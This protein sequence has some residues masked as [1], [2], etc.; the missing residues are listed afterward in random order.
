MPKPVY[1][2]LFSPIDIG[3]VR[4]KNRVVMTGFPLIVAEDTSR[5][6]VVHDKYID[7][8]EARAKGG[9]GLIVLPDTFPDR[10]LRIQSHPCIGGDEFN[11]GLGALTEAVHT[12]GAK[13]A[14][15]LMFPGISMGEWHPV[16]PFGHEWS[17]LSTNPLNYDPRVQS[18]AETSVERMRECLNLYVEAA[19][20]AKVVG[21]DFIHLAGQ[22]GF[23]IGQYLS[24]AT[25]HRTDKYGG[26]FEN[27]LRYPLEI[28]RAIKDKIGD[29]LP[30]IFRM[31][32]DE[33]C[34]GGLTIDDTTE[35]A[36]RLEA[37]GVDALNV[38]V[39]LLMS[40]DPMQRTKIM[41]PTGSAQGEF[42]PLAARIKKAVRIPV[43]IVG[44][45]T[46]PDFAERTLVED[47]ADMIGMARQLVAD[48]EWPL[49]AFE[50]RPEDIAPCIGC[51]DCHERFFT[52]LSTRC[53]VNATVGR[54]REFRITPAHKALKVM[55]I[56]GG[57]AGME[58]ARIASLRGHKVSLYEKESTLGG[59]LNLA[60]IPPHKEDL[61]DL[62]QYLVHQVKTTPVSVR[63]D[64]T[65]TLETV[66]KANPDLVVLATGGKP[67]K[68]DLPGRGT[69]KT[70]SAWEVLKG[71]VVGKRVVIVGGG[72]VGCETAE[73]LMEKGKN[74]TVIE[75]L[76]EIASDVARHTTRVLLLE[77]FKKSTIKVLVNAKALALS[78]SGLEVNV[79]GKKIIV[80]ADTFVVAT[81]TDSDDSLAANIPA[82]PWKA[83]R[84]GD[85]NRPARLI[86]AINQASYI[87]RLI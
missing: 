68:L 72:M 82:G 58:F 19:Q 4:V 16:F 42:V 33:F 1:K 38:T 52:N 86:D 12:W 83:I 32:A 8:W 50:G 84:I 40:P 10:N 81:G 23:F 73:Y 47:Q 14:P 53:S 46:K 24:P 9:A 45:I 21:F 78:K 3:R 27:R 67:R 54:E 69:L 41:P 48:A 61:K 31:S 62:W 29:D 59:Q 5:P 11:P 87:A 49:K 28:I 57:P 77:R 22:F 63:T 36:R 43:T 65:V 34:D 64:S 17:P 25:N 60:S 44:R 74:V 85:C 7:F 37:E 80:A 51:N 15:D 30:M 20:R 35:I 55:V 6:G 18:G 13:I 76:P 71:A 70:V 79:K 39:G 56:G 66:R 75:M 2:T 26:S